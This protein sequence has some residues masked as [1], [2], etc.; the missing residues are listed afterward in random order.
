LRTFCRATTCAPWRHSRARADR[1]GR[2]PADHR[3]HDVPVQSDRVP[4]DR[5]SAQPRPRSSSPSTAGSAA[6]ITATRLKQEVEAGSPGPV[7]GPDGY[8]SGQTA[9]DL[10]RKTQPKLVEEPGTKAVGTM[11]IE[12]PGDEGR[13]EQLLVASRK[14]VEDVRCHEPP[15]ATPLSRAV[16]LA[17]APTA[18]SA[19]CA[20]LD[21]PSAQT[22]STLTRVAWS[23][24]A[25]RS[26][27]SE[28]S[29]VPPGSAKATTSA[30]TAEP[31][32]ACRRSSAARRASGS[33]I[34]STTSHVFRKRFASASRPA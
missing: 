26:S 10:G 8:G 3:H 25:S 31:R 6:P 17:S 4:R 1:R 11:L 16:S 18:C 14:E 22:F 20:T 24:S 9:G 2:A 21:L 13:M 32:R 23:A 30:S 5:L 27:R 28:V 19:P 12:K 7:L 33:G 34:S 29:A 15:N